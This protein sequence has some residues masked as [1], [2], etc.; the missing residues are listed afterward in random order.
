MRDDIHK[1]TF[2]IA[3]Q[4]SFD[5]FLAGH[6]GKGLL[7][8]QTYWIKDF[9]GRIALD[10]I[11]RFESLADDF[12][13]ICEA[14]RRPDITLPH[15]LKTHNQGYHE[16]YNPR[17]IDLISKVYAEEIEMFGYTFDA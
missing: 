14:I 3:D 8:P 9:R 12:R 16:H 7:R 11:G 1:I 2:G 4:L 17:S 6:C 5:A 15:E 13:A 10:Y